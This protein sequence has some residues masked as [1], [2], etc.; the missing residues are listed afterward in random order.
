MSRNGSVNPGKP[1]RWRGLLWFI[2]LGGVL[3]IARDR[4]APVEP[5]LPPAGFTIAFIGDSDDESSFRDV[6]ALIADQGADMVVHNGDFSYETGPTRA[7]RNAIDEVLGREFPYVGA[8]G[9]HDEWAEYD[10]FFRDRLASM[11][12]DIDVGSVESASY[13]FTYQN[14]RFVFSKEGGDARHIST[15]FRRAPEAVWRFAGWHFNQSEMQVGGKPDEQGWGDYEEAR[16]AGAIITTGHEHS[17]SRT[18]TLSDMSRQT[19]AVDDRFLEV[20]EPG[21]TFAIVNGLGGRSV[22]DQERCLPTTYP[23]GCPEWAQIYTSDQGATF[24][25]L[26]ITVHVDG[27]AR[28]GLGR[29]VTVDGEVVDQFD[30]LIG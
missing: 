20:V 21:Q 7:W 28:R 5:V 27:D 2:V 26:F 22:R 24:G 11:E 1:L 15:G 12:V 17:Y 13:A 8:D 19:V 23:Y 14:I 25:A 10:G 18:K 6:L 9:N 3:V 29:F 16:R 30:I 4:P